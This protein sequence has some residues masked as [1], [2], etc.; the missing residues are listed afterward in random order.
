M[1]QPQSRVPTIVDDVAGAEGIA[2][3]FARKYEAL[4]QSV[5]TTDTDMQALKQCIDE[6][7]RDHMTESVIFSVEDVG[8]AIRALKPG[9]SDGR[10]LLSDNLVHGGAALHE[11]LT[12]LLNIMFSHG[13][14]PEALLVSTFISIPKNLKASLNNSN[15]YRS[16]ALCSAIGKVIDILI[17]NRWSDRLATSELQFGFKKNHSTVLCT[18][19]M[20]EI[21]CHYSN[22]NSPVY[23][24]FLDASKAF[25]KVHYG[26]LFSLLLKRNIPPLVLRLLLDAY[27]RQNAS[28]CWNG[29]RSNPFALANGVK[30]GG[31]L[32]P[33]LFTVYFDELLHRLQRTGIGCHVGDVYSGALCYADDLTLLCPS[34]RGLNT[35][36]QICADF[37][38]EYS[39]AF[40]ATKTVAVTFDPKNLR[41]VPGNAFL[42][43]EAIAWAK[44]TK[45]LGN[46]VQSN[47]SDAR[48]IAYKKGL[49]IGSFNNLMSNFH[50]V[51]YRVRCRLFLTNCMSYYGSQ[52]WSLS[53]PE[54][55]TLFTSWNVAVRRLL[56]LPRT[57][58]TWSLAPLLGSKHLKN[59]LLH[60]NLTFLKNCAGNTNA[61]VNAV[62]SAA[63]DDARTHM[64]QNIAKMRSCGVFNFDNYCFIEVE[65]PLHD[66]QFFS[67]ECAR[68]ILYYLDGSIDIPV[69]EQSDANNFLHFLLCG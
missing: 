23:A 64:G 57:A 63:Y 38:D 27:T 21:V 25:D 66:D 31:I 61:L 44:E 34:L 42:N 60:R 67:V 65:E 37:A 14:V 8:R 45:H 24:V 68:E 33:I 7:M 13:Y 3:V 41:V 1:H 6:R 18:A 15:N 53:C 11:H 43:G 35:M 56:K 47:L 5:P 2:E 58:H 22:K 54:L 55:C 20:K 12:L 9:K 39:V 19:V 46:Y 40:N 62:F 48:D 49:F 28:V 16:I 36:L 51:S 50:F 30:Q 10:A 26:R 4:F 69:L 29:V 32:S 17:L 52:M 59:Q